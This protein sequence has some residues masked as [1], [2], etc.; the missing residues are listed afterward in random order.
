MRAELRAR[1]GRLFDGTVDPTAY[2]L[3]RV[4]I[5][6]LVLLRT[7]DWLRP[8]L[9]L[10]H[11]AWVTGTEYAPS[12]ERVTEPRLA[13]PL[14]PG[15]A[16]WPDSI[17]EVLVHG[18]TALAAL[19][20]LGIA[21]RPVALALA[22]IGWGLMAADRF[23]YLHHLHLL[24]IACAWLALCPTSPH[25]APRWP[26]QILRVQVLAI[27]A[28]AGLAKL[29]A[30]WLS[31]RTLAQ[32]ADANLVTLPFDPGATGWAVAA[33]AVAGI[34]LALVPLLALRRTRTA[35]VVLA[36]ALHA[37]IDASMMVSTFSATMVLLVSLFLPWGEVVKDG[38]AR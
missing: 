34:E 15:L 1:I 38:P 36:I 12:I 11:H 37:M 35:A 18:R 3:L 32:L 33:A 13:S 2:T 19:L 25:P 6:T 20:L 9:R 26:A 10:D 8:W 31:G 4:G 5:A 14:I 22:A 23:R 27:Y 29:D 28:A 21:S 16:G 17:V 30:D 7:N 24:F